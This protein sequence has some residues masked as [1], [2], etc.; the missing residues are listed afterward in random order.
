MIKENLPVLILKG[1]V[2]L[3]NNDIRIEF[4]NDLNK[5]IINIS[6]LFHDN[7]ILIVNEINNKTLPKAGLIAKLK[8]KIVLPNGKMRIIISGLHRAQVHEYL[9]HTDIM[10]AIIE[11]ENDNINNSEVIIKKIQKEFQKF[12][13]I[14]PTMSNT[15]ITKT[16]TNDLS[17]LIDIIA[18]NIS[19]DNTRL[20]QYLN[21]LNIN[22]R[23]KMLLE[24]LY[25]QEEIYEIENKIDIEVQKQLNKNQKEFILKEKIKQI[26]N[27]LNENAED[28]LKM[29]IDS[30]D[31]KRNIKDKLLREYN[32]YISMSAFS[33]EAAIIKNYI[34]YLISLPWN[35]SSKDEKN[36]KKV[37]QILDENHFGMN[38]AKE[39]ILEYLAI[40]QK[41]KSQNGT[42]LCLIGPPGVGKSTIAYSIAKALK[43]EFTKI[44]L[45]SIN[46]IAEIVGHRRTYVGSFPGKII[47]QIKKTKTNNPVFLIDEI[48]KISTNDLFNVLLDILDRNQNKYFVDNYIEEEFDLSKV[49]FIL[50]AN[51][52]EKIPYYLKD[53]L[54]II[55]FDSYT[56]FEKL[57]I[58]QSHIIPKL[59]QN[60]K[61]ESLNIAKEDILYI[62]RNYTKESGIRDLERKLDEIIKKIVTS[63]LIDDVKYDIIDKKTITNILGKINYQNKINNSIGVVNGLAY[64]NYGGDI[65]TIETTHYQGNGNLILTGSLGDTIKE[66]ANI[67]LSYLKAN[68]KEFHINYEELI[69]SDIHINITNSLKKDGASAGIAILTSLISSFTNKKINSTIALTGELTLSGNIREIGGLKEK[70]IGALK[71]NIKEIIMPI[72]NKND[73]EEIEKEIKKNIKF[74]LIDNYIEIKNIFEV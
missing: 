11:L 70:I 73:L 56:E 15:L 24:D 53:R 62:I 12:V 19:L 45:S 13:D 42:I 71:N 38:K 74:T 51:D 8:N 21:T 18:Y 59:C 48:D 72:N 7:R 26:K 67:A 31:A 4:E 28:E 2:L 63:Q 9:N 30:L 66:S 47:S 55:Q 14:I 10:E 34:E 23:V 61:I 27:E 1:I 58:A 60:N 36:L 43:R 37:K 32:K 65:I 54:D 35:K 68:Y 57:E 39:K 6:E 25:K 22:D 44:T 52:I 5:N 49:L 16:N 64:T 3:P 50:T 69:T 41:T 40:K 17:K 33:P 20:F 46:D 29:K